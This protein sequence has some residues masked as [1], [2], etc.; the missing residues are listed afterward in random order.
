MQAKDLIRV[1]TSGWNFDSWAGRFYEEDIKK[2][3]MLR[4]YAD[5]FETVELNNSFYSLPE[6]KSI[7]S[8][9]EDVSGKFLFSCKA[10]RYITH[11]KKLKEPEEGV[12]ALLE[13][14]EPFEKNLGPI[15]FQLPPKWSVDKERLEA[16]LKYL[17]E[18]HRYSFEF[19]DRSWLCDDV[20]TL[21]EEYGA[22]LCFYD[23]EGFQSPEIPTADFIYVRLHGTH[24]K[25]YEG[26]YDGR[27]LAGYAQKFLNWAQEGKDVFCYLDNDKKSCAP[28]DAQRLKE[29]IKRQS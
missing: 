17:P 25:A 9:K 2:E 1:G 6:E 21:L 13:A 5:T 18:K 26:S 22:A 7:K 12:D 24:R 10:S 16:F 8:W 3:E 14:L 11:M 29:S 15:L 20:Y 23:Y 28:Q 19:R 27:T 4:A